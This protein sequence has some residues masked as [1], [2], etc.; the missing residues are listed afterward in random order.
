MEFIQ[1]AQHLDLEFIEQP[2][3]ADD[4]EGMQSMPKSVRKLTA[5]DESLLNVQN[6]LRFTHS[7]QPFGIYNIKLMKCGGIFPALQIAEIAH[8]ANIDL[9]WGCMDES[10]VSISAALHAALASPATRYVDIDGSLNLARDLVEG[11]FV[12]QNGQ[13]TI[14]DKPGLGVELK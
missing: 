6:A 9:M 13:L 8:L 3:K 5:A 7:P 4:I 14:T 1:R 2:L 12:L 11:G 10:I